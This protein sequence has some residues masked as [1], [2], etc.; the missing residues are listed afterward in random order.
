[1]SPP[2]PRGGSRKK[3]LRRASGARTR[4]HML[5]ERTFLRAR[6][7]TRLSPHK[8]RHALHAP[9]RRTAL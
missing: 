5:R 3:Q 4:Q 2:T 6:T 1:M 7:G 8:P 9:H